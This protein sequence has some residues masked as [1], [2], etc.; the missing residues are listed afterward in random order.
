LLN[1]L[2]ALETDIG[3]LESE[4][5]KSKSRRHDLLNQCRLERIEL[6]LAIDE[7]KNEFAEQDE[8]NDSEPFMLDFEGILLVIQSILTNCS[9]AIQSL[10]FDVLD[11][12]TKVVSGDEFSSMMSAYE[13]ELQTM[14]ASIEKL[15]PNLKAIE[16]Y[17]EISRTFILMFCFHR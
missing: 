17:D 9:I 15:N 1:I 14:D 3:N 4:I 10:D 7:R 8:T 16:Q 2:G 6:P 5:E 12:Q 13:S 11:R